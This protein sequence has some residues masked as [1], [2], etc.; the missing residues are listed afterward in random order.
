M[1]QYDRDSIGCR[2]LTLN[3][4][5]AGRG[6]QI[7]RSAFP[8]APTCGTPQTVRATLVLCMRRGIIN[9][10]TR[11]SLAHMATMHELG[12]RSLFLAKLP[13]VLGAMK[14]DLIRMDVQLVLGTLEM[15]GRT[16]RWALSMIFG[17]HGSSIV[18]PITWRFWAR[19]KS[20]SSLA[21]NALRRPTRRYGTRNRT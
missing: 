9:V 15:Q 20:M 2:F 21:C 11:L 12:S 5:G 14:E 10:P 8:R 4:H 18:G 7:P 16:A 19:E 1:S 3:F 6:S 17:L 13:Q